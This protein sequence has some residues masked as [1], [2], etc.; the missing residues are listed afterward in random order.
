M[1]APRALTGA[2]ERAKRP[3]FRRM[4]M[5]TLR[6]PPRL[7]TA[8]YAIALLCACVYIATV[9]FRHVFL[10]RL[11]AL[12]GAVILCWAQAGFRFPWSLPLLVP[13][14]LWAAL[15]ALSVAY[16]A[17]RAQAASDFQ[18]EILFAF[19]AYATWYELAQRRIAVRWLAITLA[20]TVI[21]VLAAG[22]IRLCAGDAPLT[23]GDYSDVGTIST[24][25]VTVLPV[26]LALTLRA[27]PHSVER[28]AAV[29]LVIACLAAGT[30]TQNRMFAFASGVE[31]I[32]FALFSM[33]TWRTP[34]PGFALLGVVALVAGLAVASLLFASQSRIAVYAPGTGVVEFLAEDPRLDLWR[35]AVTQIGAHPWI[36][37]GLGKWTSQ[38][39]F[40]NE[41]HDAYRMHAHNVFL[42]R[43]LETGLPG[44]AAFTVLLA[45]VAFA[46]WKQSL[47]TVRRNAA[48]GVA[49]LALVAG[50]VTKN[51]TDDFFLRQNAL[52]FWSLAGAVLG[53]AKRHPGAVTAMRE[54]ARGA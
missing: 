9:P 43:A 23:L 39:A 14:A 44:L 24:F 53:A 37:A 52:L 31:I 13:W 29:A 27:A 22:V 34:R 3:G 8:L 51:L 50:V 19:V 18:H 20:A 15:A 21:V 30:W 47:S 6:L 46:F 28:V 38:Q 11:L 25:L 54:A 1:S 16:A 10:L 49:G 4:P 35:F 2:R 7:S 5:P 45:A 40:Y 32:V 33:R 36:G 12:S 48:L 41:F 42:N 17:N 26:L